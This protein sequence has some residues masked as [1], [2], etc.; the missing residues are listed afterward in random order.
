[1][2]NL[3]DGSVEVL[4][5]GERRAVGAMADRLREGPRSARVDKVERVAVKLRD[6]VRGFTIER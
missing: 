1:M 2:R 6:S 5:R 3:P 4:V